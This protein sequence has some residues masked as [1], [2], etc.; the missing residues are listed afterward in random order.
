MEMKKI[1]EDT[2]NTL[3]S[4]AQLTNDC[5]RNLFEGRKVIQAT[6]IYV[7]ITA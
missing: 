7:L 4:W 3:N 2:F 1:M 6:P 5:M